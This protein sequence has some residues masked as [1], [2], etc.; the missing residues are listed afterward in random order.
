MFLIAFAFFFLAPKIV[1]AD[2]NIS[3]SDGVS[4]P[5]GFCKDNGGENCIYDSGSET[6]KI[7]ECGGVAVGES[8]DQK[9]TFCQEM[10]NCEY[11]SASNS[12]KLK[13]T[14]T[15]TP[16]PP[17]PDVELQFPNPLAGDASNAHEIS[18]ATTALIAKVISAILGLL[19]S[20]SLLVFLIGGVLYLVSGGEE[21]KVKKSVDTLKWAFL[22]LVV[23]FAAYAILN[24]IL[25][26]L[27]FITAS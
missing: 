18:I 7:K 27:S 16:T 11:D 15:S 20:V 3:P 17:N 26:G 1:W 6:C 2:C 25:E 21:A 12:C 23:V 5:T 9:Q 14:T 13:S 24:M 22:G 4:D 19:G 8:T 10:T